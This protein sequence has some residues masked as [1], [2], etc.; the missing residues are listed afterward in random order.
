M[1]ADSLKPGI[2]V[3]LKQ[4]IQQDGHGWNVCINSASPGAGLLTFEYQGSEQLVAL[5]GS[6][7]GT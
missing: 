7:N 6:K 2:W 4:N 1:D 3:F 5:F